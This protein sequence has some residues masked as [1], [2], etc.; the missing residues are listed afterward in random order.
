MLRRQLHKKCERRDT[1]SVSAF[2]LV[3]ILLGII[4]VG[5]IGLD[6][7]HNVTTRTAEQSATDA[8]AL[9]GAAYIAQNSTGATDSL[10]PPPVGQDQSTSFGQSSNAQTTGVNV[11]GNNTADGKQLNAGNNCTVTAS[12]VPP[13]APTAKSSP[14]PGNNG[15]CQVSS[16]MQITNMFSAIFGR[17][18]ESIP[19]QSTATAY[20]T[21]IGVNPN[22]L[23]PIAVSIDTQGGHYM[24][25]P[26]NLPLY[27]THVGSNETFTLSEPCANAA[28]TTFN[29][30]PPGQ[31]SVGPN[32]TN[33]TN[34]INTAL[35]PIL[36]TS[37]SSNVGAQ[38]VGEPSSAAAQPG[39]ID[40]W[41]DLAGPNSLANVTLPVT[42]NLPVIAG[43]QPFRQEPHGN[44][45]T[46]TQPTTPQTHPLLGFIGFKITN[47]NYANGAVNY[48]QGQIVKSLVTGTPGV[49][50]PTILPN[51]VAVPDNPVTGSPQTAAVYNEQLQVALQNL[52]P[53]IVM[54]GNTNLSLGPNNQPF[55][56]GGNGPIPPANTD[57]FYSGGATAVASAIE[58]VSKSPLA[59]TTVA[60]YIGSPT[61]ALISST[62]TE[63]DLGG[64]P[65]DV[66]YSQVMVEPNTPFVIT[67]YFTDETGLKAVKGITTWSSNGSSNVTL[68]TPLS[69]A[70]VPT[71]PTLGYGQGSIPSSW[72]VPSGFQYQNYTSQITINVP[73]LTSPCVLQMNTLDD[74]NG[75]DNALTLFDIQFPPCPVQ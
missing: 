11:T 23:F 21:A 35:G 50:N 46:A 14:Y 71:P 34:W 73:A 39:G 59:G 47:I 2:L 48:I 10:G 32:E 27:L 31:W 64:I 37:T 66:A 75:G 13:S 61:G 55:G 29:Q 54:L 49:A 15:Q 52:S 72:Q 70:T 4:A 8:G 26:D 12:T 40:L 7:A 22:Q 44:A 43:D 56:T 60:T 30:L 65:G 9:S 63:P 5:A 68:S 18:T 25:D 28:W 20:N 16:V 45:G 1:G 69:W 53:S 62:Q 58:Q 17:K 57:N 33:Q 36:G 3:G 24:S 42:V 6:I 19:V 67:A 74:D 51:G 41:A 38:T